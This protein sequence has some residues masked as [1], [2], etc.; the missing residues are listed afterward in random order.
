M[1]KQ[2]RFLY[3]VFALAWTV[4]ATASQRSP[5]D[6]NQQTLIELERGW[7]DAFY[8][9]DVAFIEA[10]LADEFVATYDDGSRGDK[11]RELTLTAEFNQQVESATQED[12]M[13]RTFGDAAVVWFTLRLVGIRQGQRA[14]VTFRYTDVW[15]QRD[16]RWQ[17]VSTQ[18]TRISAE[19]SG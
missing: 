15:I 9:Q 13:V 4:T 14:E 7:N 5:S 19:S 1:K 16:G 3:F 6:S 2:P 12:F 10:L 11:A 18:S 17:C 8:R